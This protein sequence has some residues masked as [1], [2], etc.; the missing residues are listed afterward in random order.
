[1]G[2]IT[3]GFAEY[4]GDP[5][6]LNNI[7]EHIEKSQKI[8]VKN[9]GF[10]LNYDNVLGYSEIKYGR[11]IINPSVIDIDAFAETK[12]KVITFNKFM[13]DDSAFLKKEYDESVKAK[14]FAQG[15]TYLNIV[16][17]EIG[18]QYDK[19]SRQLYTKIVDEINTLAYNENV[20]IDA[21]IYNNISR[22]ALAKTE[23]GRYTELIS[24]LYAQLNGSTPEFART[25][26]LKIGVLN[27][28]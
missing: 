17:H 3:N 7:L 1:M 11:K 9:S 15:T 5:Q 18:H 16:D 6:I 25:I 27:E 14:Q 8:N 2:I 12:G 10:I 26:F 24:E 21:Y 19:N 22:Y 23:E 20:T 28:S 4:R 13:F